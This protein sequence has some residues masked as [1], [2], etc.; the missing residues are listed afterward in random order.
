[1]C[2]IA[3]SP[4]RPRSFCSSKT[5]ATRP[6]SRSGRQPAVVGD[7][8]PRRLLAAVLEREQAEVGEAG[9]VAR[10][11]RGCRT[12]RTSGR[13]QAS[14]QTASRGTPSSVYR[15]RRPDLAQRHAGRASRRR[16]PA[17]TAR[18]A[19]PPP[20]PNSATRVVRQRRARRRSPLDD[21][22]LR[23]RDGEAAVGGVVRER[24]AA[25]P[26]RQRNSISAA[27]AARSSARAGRRARRRAPGTRSR[28][29][30]AP[31][32]RRAGPRRPRASAPGTR[33]DVARRARRSRPPASGGSR[34]RPVSL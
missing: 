25:A 34:G 13:A 21:R 8:D 7:G 5:C 12:R 11:A 19:W 22:R 31:A 15:R 18:T 17:R 3:T 28:R 14:A 30:R 24:A 32:R 20:S 4:R 1:M 33:A 10:R 27:S 16:R 26:L 2:P 23:Q 6:M 29:A 9:D